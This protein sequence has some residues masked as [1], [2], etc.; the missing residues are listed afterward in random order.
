[1]FGQEARLALWLVLSWKGGQKLRK[2]AVMNQVLVIQ[3]QYYKGY[4][5]AFWASCRL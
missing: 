5:L 1:M 2:V 4:H 3:G